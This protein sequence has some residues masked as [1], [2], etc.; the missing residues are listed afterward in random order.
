VTDERCDCGR[1][2]PLVRGGVRGRLDDVIFYTGVKVSPAAG[3]VAVRA[4]PGLG[5][6]YRLEHRG[7][8]LTLTAEALD[9]V[10][11]ARFSALAAAL[12]QEFTRLTSLRIPATIVRAGTLARAE[13]KSRRVVRAAE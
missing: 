13:M 9:E 4:V 2:F 8:T 3:E 7:D 12:Q 1:S 5:L 6:E 10:D 11:A